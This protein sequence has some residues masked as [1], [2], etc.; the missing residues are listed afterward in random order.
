MGTFLARE[1]QERGKW[2]LDPKI[3][4]AQLF[5]NVLLYVL[6]ERNKIK[7]L[8]RYKRRYAIIIKSITCGVTEL[9]F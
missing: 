8:L 3:R 5:E 7:I 1:G 6:V 4:D 9:V 2:E